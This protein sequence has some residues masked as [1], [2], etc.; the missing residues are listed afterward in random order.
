MHRISIRAMVIFLTAAISFAAE[1]N[2]TSAPP[3]GYV[4]GPNDEI[5]VTVAELPEFNG[6]SYRIDEDGTVSLPLLGR[7][8]AGGLTLPQL[9]SNLTQSLKRQVIDPHLTAN[10]IETRKQPVSVMGEVTTPGTQMI[11]GDKTLFDVIAAAGGLKVDA[12]D[13]IRITRRASEGQLDLPD[14]VI[15]KEAGRSS[16]TVKVHDV[17]DLRD[18]RANIRVRANDE[19]FIARGPVLYV[20][21]NVHKPGGFTMSQGKP[22]Y[23]LEALS[24]AEGFTLNAAPSNARIL[25]RGPDTQA[26]QEIPV[27]LKKILAGKSEDVKLSPDDILFIPDNTSR[28]ATTKVL[29]T[30]LSTISGVVIWRG[31]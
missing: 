7:V 14:E 25:R 8:R 29:E 17:V 24:L 30:A 11:Q 1:G 23:T 10:I 18:A 6:K 15:D 21:G 13:V 3:A 26:R 27:N 28:R 22:V 9:E 2:R 5:N 20:I 31:L 12:G 4:L 19:V 16:G